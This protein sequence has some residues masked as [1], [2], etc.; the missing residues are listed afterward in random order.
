MRD[1][2]IQIN[3]WINFACDDLKAAEISVDKG[4]ANIVCFHS[5]QSVE[6]CLKALYLYH[7]DTI[8]KTHDLEAI[9]NKLM[10]KETKISEHT[11]QIRYLNK[12]Y[13]PT[14]YPD[15]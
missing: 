12:F 5:Q 2:D 15:A 10:E 13:I 4:I 9:V 3:S 1:K 14:R 11:E 7:F 6:K 8:P